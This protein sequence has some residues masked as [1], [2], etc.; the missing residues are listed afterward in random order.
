MGQRRV[1]PEALREL[2]VWLVV[3][4]LISLAGP[5]FT[6]GISWLGGGNANWAGLLSGGLVL[7]P[8]VSMAAGALAR[9]VIRRGVTPAGMDLTVF[10]GTLVVVVVGTFVYV[11]VSVA[12]ATDAGRL[13]LAS[14]VVLAGALLAGAGCTYRAASG[15]AGGDGSGPTPATPVTPPPQPSGAVKSG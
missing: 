15:G 2:V 9:M 7:L 6:I 4:A 13:A 5:L 1:N 11:D 8:S 10:L 3:G 12:K 14:G